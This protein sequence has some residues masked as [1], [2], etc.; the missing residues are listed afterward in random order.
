M[1]T[2][3]KRGV[4]A[5]TRRTT[6]RASASKRTTTKKT[7]PKRSAAAGA[8]RSSVAAKRAA[9]K[10]AVKTVSTKKQARDAFKTLN[11]WNWVLA[12]LSAAQG[13]VILF[14]SKAVSYPV[15]TNFLT[16]D[17]IAESDSTVLI[18]ARRNLF[19]IN[20]AYL[21]A[22]FFF[23]SALV[24]LYLATVG[25]K[26]YRTDLEDRINRLRW[27]DLG[28]SVGVVMLVVAMLVGVSSVS[29]LLLIF[30]ATFIAGML[31]L[32]IEMNGHTSGRL[33]AYIGIKS[34]AFVWLVI[35]LQLWG[36]YQYG[37]GGNLPGYV[38]YVA[39][40]AFVF[41]LGFIFNLILSR[42]GIGRWSDYL[43]GEKVYMSLSLLTKAA[44]AW[45][46]FV[47]ILQA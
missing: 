8:K 33:N 2:T 17:S 20:L 14:L 34:L 5:G 3:T 28:L 25:R 31:G 38:Y 19:D 36:S 6:G 41:S 11:I 30:G 46:L 4:A 39:G 45:L 21:I 16:A 43:Y 37:E 26:K 29:T 22:A 7:T 27:L 18:E 1:A 32:V 44:V 40:S 47:N 15:T 35:G 12:I 24:H 13:V 10:P 42:K 23:V 9:K